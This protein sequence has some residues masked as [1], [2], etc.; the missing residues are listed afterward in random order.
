LHF[1]LQNC[2]YL[3]LAQKQRSFLLP[4]RPLLSGPLS[5]ILHLL[6]P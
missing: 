6:T 1:H 5:I 2:N 4:P 3:N